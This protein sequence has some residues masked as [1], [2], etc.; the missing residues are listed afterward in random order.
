MRKTFCKHEKG[1]PQVA[2]SGQ[3]LT[4]CRLCGKVMER[5]YSKAPKLPTEKF[6]KPGD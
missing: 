4:L 2:E 6:P 1:E 3:T 5:A